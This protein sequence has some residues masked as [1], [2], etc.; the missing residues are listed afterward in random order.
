MPHNNST[1]SLGSLAILSISLLGLTTGAIAGDLEPP[2][3]VPQSTMKTL[4]EIEPRIPIDPEGLDSITIDQPG[5][6]FLTKPA[7]IT[8]QL[9][10]DSAGVVLNLNG[11]QHRFGDGIDI[12]AS[13][14]DSTVSVENGTLIGDTMI[15]VVDTVAVL[16]E[17]V[18]FEGGGIETSDASSIEISNSRFTGNGGPAI[19]VQFVATHLSIEGCYFEGFDEA[20]ILEGTGQQDSTVVRD[21]KFRGTS[22][23]I[24][25][26]G[27][28]TLE[29]LDCT[30]DGASNQS[31]D[32]LRAFHIMGDI[33]FRMYRSS[34]K[35]F[36]QIF[37]V[38]A[39]APRLLVKD[40]QFENFQAV[41]SHYSQGD[42]GNLA[43]ED[44]SFFGG[45]SGQLIESGSGALAARF[46]GSNFIGFDRL[47]EVSLSL[48]LDFENCSFVGFSYHVWPSGSSVLASVIEVD[49]ANSFSVGEN[50]SFVSTEISQKGDSSFDYSI[51]CDATVTFDQCVFHSIR[52]GLE[53]VGGSV[54]VR[55]C[56]FSSRDG[57]F[58]G[59][60]AIRNSHFDSREAILVEDTSITGYQNA[61]YGNNFQL[62]EITI[63]DCQRA[64]NN[65]SN[66]QLSDSN[67]FVEELGEVQEEAVMSDSNLRTSNLG[68]WVGQIHARD[69]T[70][71]N[72]DIGS[73]SGLTI[74]GYNDYS[75]SIQDCS[76]SGFFEGVD[77]NTSS[78]VSI[79][80]SSFS[81][82]T[83]AIDA[84]SSTG[85][86]IVRN[87]V[88]GSSTGI[89]GGSDAVVT[90]NVVSVEN[91]GIDAQGLIAK[92][93]VMSQSGSA[94]NI[95]S[96]INS[97]TG[98]DLDP[99][100]PSYIPQP[101]AN[102][103]E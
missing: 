92:N 40:S 71:S 31:A 60:T 11:L 68:L 69:C 9:Q 13:S 20:I 3:G 48:D 42:D 99:L 52:Y 21:S 65:L 5:H 63:N 33:S 34:A 81:Q 16:V 85:S 17:G 19:H 102:I 61:L 24:L 25:V 8:N 14:I 38:D 47:T 54:V 72:Q 89:Y 66:L 44:S 98:S 62:R 57:F 28:G 29:V 91:T 73:S 86:V 96:P 12:T 45:D 56:T 46:S 32:G 27:N 7:D 84:G 36:Q 74:S 6:Y 87:S 41:L 59:E 51:I 90:E 2:S 77:L 43:F 67:I 88:I 95:G 1:G 78:G 97:I 80:G 64:F 50:C 55:G 93:Q 79:S 70:F 49:G 10:I 103:Y 39:H 37:D 94:Y 83:V 22:Q 35:N 82:C 23:P 26:D 18:T 58:R 30:F 75:G 76:F 100:N 15:E 4:D 53:I 101:W